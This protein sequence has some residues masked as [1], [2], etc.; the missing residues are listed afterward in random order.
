MSAM[1]NRVFVSH[2]SDLARVPSG[3]S[4]VQAVLDAVARAGMLAVD[5]R[6]FAAREGQPAEFCQQQVR[7]CDIYLAVVGFRYGSL[8]P[9]EAVSY[10]ELEFDEASA[11]G[12]P[13]LVFLLQEP[14]MSE[15]AGA[16]RLPADVFDGDRAAVDRFRQR[17][18]QAGLI[19]VEFAT[20]DRLELA[21][22]QALLEL[23]GTRQRAVPRQLPPAVG[24]FAGRA[25]ELA[26]LADLLPSRVSAGGTVVIS[27]I[28][29]TAGV[30]KT[31]LAVFW[32]HQV[33]DRFPDGQLYVNLRGFDPGGQVMGPGAVLRRFL[34]ALGVQPQRIPADLDAQAALFRTTVAG[35]RMLIV[36]DNARDSAQV[37]PLLPGARGCLVVVTSRNRLSGLVA[38]E[39]AHPLSLSLLTPAEARELLARRLG[40]RRLAAEPAAVE[41]IITAC[42]RLPLALAI[43]A[44]RAI[45]HPQLSLDALADELRDTHERLGRLTSGEDAYTDI[46]EVLSWS[47]QSLTEQAAKLFRL[48]GLHPGPDITVEAAASLVGVPVSV[49][50]GLLTELSRANLIVEQAP[51]RY[52]FH[53][54]LRAFAADLT[55]THE[56][57]HERNAATHR[58]LDHYLHTAHTAARHLHPMITPPSITPSP[59]QTGVTTGHVGDHQQALAWF[60]SEHAVLLAIIDHAFA[61]G[62]NTHVWYLAWTMWAFLNP[63]GRWHDYAATARAAVTAAQRLANPTAQ[64]YAHLQ[65]ATADMR[66]GHLDD[67]HTQ[68]RHALDLY[69]QVGDQGDSAGQAYTHIAIAQVL[70]QQDLHSDAMH[71][72]H[73]ALELFRAVDHRRGQANALSNIGFYRTLLGDYQQALTTCQQALALLNELGDRTGQ[74]ATWDSIGYANHH[75][76]HYTQAITCY[77]HAA[78]LFQDLGNRY[79]E[80]TVLSHLGESHQAT[81]N[82]HAAR[83][84]WQQAHNILKELDHPDAKQIEDKI[85]TLDTP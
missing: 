47:Y 72:A 38:A 64:A 59:I 42:A 77:E 5:M 25:A 75:L 71:H 45:G 52:T 4:Y 80:A 73:Q 51:G 29:G 67:A 58:M 49:A 33:R 44:A 81:D 6:Y 57:P 35:L 30:G 17:L 10:T 16:M 36:L 39:G 37:R 14:A 85:A 68:L 55:R 9:G 32:A 65:L 56:G 66:L 31:A 54:L 46:R 41:Q 62:Y 84:A 26:A 83:A 79:F 61:S 27:A 24:H 43:V 63:R 40:R 60:T 53:D 8:V 28:G 12:V 20:A 22:F 74:A 23:V 50:Q 34:D 21:V 3:R 18:M 13:R 19:C 78:G 2:T 69:R 1:T 76:G 70:E 7:D 48:L 11:A 15:A 82:L